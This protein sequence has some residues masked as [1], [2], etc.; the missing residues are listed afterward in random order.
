MPRPSNLVLT[1]LNTLTLIAGL[2]LLAA[3]I[4]LSVSSS[5]GCQTFLRNSFLILA[6]FVLLVSVLGLMGSSRK[7]NAFLWIYS[8]LLL[9]LVLGAIGFTVFMLVVTTRH[10]GGASVAD[11][12]GWMRHHFAKGE[13]WEVV[14]S[15]LVDGQ[16]CRVGARNSGLMVHIQAG[17]C[18]PPPGCSPEKGTVAAE[19]NKKEGNLAGECG[20]WSPH[21]PKKMCYNCERCKA[22]FLGEVRK[23]WRAAGVALL[24]FVVFMVGVLC[25]AWCAINNNKFDSEALTKA[26]TDACAANSPSKVVVPPGD[27]TAGVT[28]FAG[29]CKAPIQFEIN[30]IIKAPKAI[31]G[32]CWFSIEDVTDLRLF[33]TGTLDGQGAACWAEKGGDQTANFRFQNII[34][35]WVE[36]ITSKDSK[37]FHMATLNCNNMT[38]SHVNVIAPADS[39]NTDGIHISRSQHI[40]VTDSTIG[41]GDDC[42]SMIDNLDTITIQNTKCGPSHGISIGSLGKRE[43]EGPVKNVFVRHCTIANSDNGI[44]IKAWPD[45][46]ATSCSGIHFEDITLDNVENPIIIDEQYCPN[47]DCKS[48]TAPSPVEISDVT[49]KNVKGTSKT[50]EIIQ[51]ICSSAHPCQNVQ[52]SNIDIT[53]N[54][55]PGV[56]VCQNVKPVIT[57]IMNPPG[58]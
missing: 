34:N 17:C 51:L 41:T 54:G 26:W 30:G 50:K 40:T 45:R 7:N 57:G 9:L 58:C 29:P 6:S 23:Q 15:C 43:K 14:R 5:S 18:K 24:C 36:G 33:G 42:V 11:F 16:A 46:F 31:K 22:G 56:A 1:I 12:S 44:R 32:D 55:G 25:M 35:G 28:M 47:G 2:S 21:D 38:F 52:M 37:F 48:K 8:A 19:G 49:F 27:Y 20:K 3:G 39:V 13:N 53:F 10:H 4:Y